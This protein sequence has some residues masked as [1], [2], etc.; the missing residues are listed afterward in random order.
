MKLDLFQVTVIS[1]LLGLSVLTTCINSLCIY[2]IIK[3]KLLLKRPSTYLILN[4]L[5]VHLLQGLIVFPLYVGKKFKVENFRWAQMFCDGFRFTYMVTFYA[6]ILGVLLIA[7]DRLLATWFVM[8][9]KEIV[10]K[11]RCIITI[12]I[13][14]MYI[15]ALCIIP[16]KKSE[17]EIDTQTIDTNN[18]KSNATVYRSTCLYNQ[19]KIWTILMLMI[20]CALPYILVVLCYQIVIYKIKKIGNKSHP[21]QNTKGSNGSK[22]LTKDIS[23]HKDITKLSITITLTYAIFWS[24]SVIYYILLS[25]CPTTCFVDNYNESSAERYIGFLAKFLPFLDALAAPLIYCFYHNEFRSLLTRFLRRG[26][27]PSKEFHSGYDDTI[28]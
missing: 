20:N 4:L 27:S 15:I 13:F 14:W 7:I 12:I 17:S 6:A 1:L 2:I 22:I 25:L 23:K 26:R 19:T 8:K 16:F 18:T 21:T 28:M 3:S 9:Y 11:R 5:T 24:P 10:T